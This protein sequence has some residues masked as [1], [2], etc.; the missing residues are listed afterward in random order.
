MHNI[1]QPLLVHVTNIPTP[2]RIAFCNVLHDVLEAAG[3]GF[4]VFY[5]AE[6]EVGRHWTISFDDM[7]YPYEVLPGI[8]ARLGSLEFHFNPSIIQRLRQLCPEFL[9]VA[10]S[11]NMPTAMMAASKSLCGPAVRVFW[12]EGHADAVRYASGPIAWTRQRCLR[13]YDAFAVPNNASARFLEAELGFRPVILPLPNTVDEDFYQAVRMMDKAQLRQELGL[14]CDAT[15][16]VSVASLDEHKGVRELAAA[17]A[18]PKVNLGR[19]VLILVGEGPLRKELAAI[20]QTGK[21]QIRLVG[22]Q[23]P[24]GV[25][26]YLAAADAF[27]L[28]TKRDPNPLAV[29]E[30]GFAGLPLLVSQKAGNVME[31]VRDGFSGMVIPAAE[32]SV[33]AATLARFCGLSDAER[34]QLGIGAAYLADTGFQRKIVAQNFVSALLESRRRR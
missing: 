28:A 11:W 22:H 32:S 21:L 33:I 31:L 16:F 5:C 20:S 19:C 23:G 10:G 34:R 3:Y 27:V 2:Y 24:F 12:S 6:R 25:R 14:P 26:A 13:T 18:D 17:M 9:L 29:I 8:S 7:K 15:V 30:A 4:Y 1:K